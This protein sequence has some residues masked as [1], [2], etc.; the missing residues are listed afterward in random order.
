MDIIVIPCLGMSLKVSFH[1][2]KKKGRQKK[3]FEKAGLREGRERGAACALLAW[4]CCTW[5]CGVIGGARARWT[6][7]QSSSPPIA[8]HPSL[9]RN[10]VLGS[11]RRCDGVV[12]HV[13]R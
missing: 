4:K 10:N 2:S 12:R 8:K 3:R 11:G 13:P 7:R 1:A 6:G 5:W 9:L